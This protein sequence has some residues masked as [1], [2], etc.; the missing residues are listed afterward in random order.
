M[1]LFAIGDLHLSFNT[2]KPMDVFEGWTDYVTRLE[3][4]WQSKVTDEDTV[5]IAGDIS[6]AM[7][8]EEAVLDFK[9]IERLKGRKIILK[10]NHDYWWNSKKK[11]CE[12]FEKNGIKSIEI[13]QNN[14]F[15]YN[16]ISICGTRGWISENGEPADAKILARE[17][18]RLEMSITSAKSNSEKIVFLHYPP[19]FLNDYNYSIIE[20]L[21]K[22]N[23]KRCY[24]GHIHGKG[25]F[26]AF[27]GVAD[28]IE[29]RLISS[30]YLKFSPLL[31]EK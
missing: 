2:N 30:D 19:I 20:V 8:I 3:R 29:Y 31:I 26:S 28:G 22:H 24:Y 11:I 4:E 1:A 21:Q 27:N 16:G 5:V 10:G 18:L 14:S 17:A 23:I 12:M 15:E 25:C 7:T 6:W 9:Y 13:L